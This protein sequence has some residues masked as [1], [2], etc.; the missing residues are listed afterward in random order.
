MVSSRS[1]RDPS[2]QSSGRASRRG[3]GRGSS[4]L[5]QTTLDATLRI[6]QSERLVLEIMVKLLRLS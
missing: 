6:R 1:S 2:E 3:R 4:S 5:K